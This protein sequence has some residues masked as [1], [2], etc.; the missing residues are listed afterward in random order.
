MI[1]SPTC[2]RSKQ[3]L[4]IKVEKLRFSFEFN[5]GTDLKELLDDIISKDIH[6]E[7]VGSL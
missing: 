4:S 6:H 5:L 7:L 1:Q 2:K 3:A